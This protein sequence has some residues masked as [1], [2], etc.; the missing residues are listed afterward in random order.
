MH[1]AFDEPRELSVYR[2]VSESI[3]AQRDDEGSASG[4]VDERSDEPRLLVRIA[5]HGHDFFGLVDNESG[6][7][8]GRRQRRQR[9]HGVCA[10]RDHD[11]AAAVATQ[12]G[13]DTGTD[14]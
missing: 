12:R 3:R 11:H 10:G 2:N 13:A 5:A 9:V 7:R 4:V 6:W 14:E 8:T 1:A